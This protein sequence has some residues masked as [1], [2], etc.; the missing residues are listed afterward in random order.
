MIGETLGI[1]FGS[2][3]S[4]IPM[5]AILFYAI[6]SYIPT[7]LLIYY[8]PPLNDI[9]QNLRRL[10]IWGSIVSYFIFIFVLFVI[11]STFSQV[12][13]SNISSSLFAGL[14]AN[15]SE[16]GIILIGIVA[17]SYI[18]IFSFYLSGGV[19][20]L[21]IEISCDMS[22]LINMTE[23]FNPIPQLG[24]SAIIL[25]FIIFAKVF[26]YASIFIYGWFEDIIEKLPES[27]STGLNSIIIVYINFI[28]LGLYCSYLVSQSQ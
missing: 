20:L 18:K 1:F 27:I 21:L 28:P 25:I 13:I 9:P 7:G 10:K 17:S 8:N 12:S 16:F 3:F 4:L 14:K 19:I 26:P 6:V 23:A 22:G 2:F 5:T 15:P 11:F 24:M